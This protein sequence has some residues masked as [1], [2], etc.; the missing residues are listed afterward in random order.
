MARALAHRGPDDHG[1]WADPAA[2]VAFGFQRLA[3]LDLS[4]QGHQ[5]M[6]SAGGRYVLVWFTRLPTDTSGTFQ[7]QVSNVALQ[8][9][10]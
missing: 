9:R 3:I 1:V 4:A 2:G 6:L 10:P 8:G 7:A 5:P